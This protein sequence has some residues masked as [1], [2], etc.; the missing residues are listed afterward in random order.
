MWP[1]KI[2]TKTRQQRYVQRGILK[3]EVWTKSIRLVEPKISPI[4]ASHDDLQDQ[5]N[6]EKMVDS[7]VSLMNI[8]NKIKKNFKF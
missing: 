4:F 3:F 7:L 6:L 8:A 2:I 1:D 5:N